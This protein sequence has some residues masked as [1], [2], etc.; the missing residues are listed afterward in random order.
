MLTIRG[1][2]DFYEGWLA[3][4]FQLPLRRGVSD[5]W[6]KGWSTVEE[7]GDEVAIDIPEEIRRGHILVEELKQDLMLTIKKEVEIEVPVKVLTFSWKE[8][9]KVE[10]LQELQ[11]TACFSE[12]G[13]RRWALA[14]VQVDGEKRALRLCEDCGVKAEANFKAEKP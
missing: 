4:I 8:H 12:L 11:C 3:R 6:H 7:L 5:D 1:S 13:P 2:T 14:W 10:S 9:L